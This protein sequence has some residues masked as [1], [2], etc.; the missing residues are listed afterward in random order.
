MV[1]AFTIRRIVYLLPGCL[2]LGTTQRCSFINRQSYNTLQSMERSSKS[3][4]TIVS[5]LTQ[6][7]LAPKKSRKSEER[8]G[9]CHDNFT[10]SSKVYRRRASRKVQPTTASI[11]L[12]LLHYSV[13]KFRYLRLAPVKQTSRILIRGY[14]SI[15]T[16]G[17]PGITSQ[18]T[19]STRKRSYAV[20][21]R[22]IPHVIRLQAEGGRICDTIV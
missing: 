19:W 5:A 22:L 14:E 12:L 1:C 8:N 7:P 6:L 11:G 18:C 10:P 13:P 9:Q 21:W 4:R 17:Q 20:V 16:F 3:R 2:H 15:V